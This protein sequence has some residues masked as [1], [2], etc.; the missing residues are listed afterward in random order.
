LERCPSAGRGVGPSA[1]YQISHLEMTAGDSRY[2]LFKGHLVDGHSTLLPPCTTNDLPINAYKGRG[3]EE[4]KR[5]ISSQDGPG[6]Y[7]QIGLQ[8]QFL[9]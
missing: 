3:E 7:I 8:R 2:W 6:D 5:L 4:G 9:R 1:S